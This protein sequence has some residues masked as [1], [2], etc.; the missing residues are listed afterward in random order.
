MLQPTPRT[1]AAVAATALVALLPALLDE[2]TWPVWT[3]AVGLVTLLVGMDA[4]IVAGV[5]VGRL[6]ASWPRRLYV[7]RPH[8]A[9]LAPSGV[10]DPGAELVLE[11]SAE[12]TSLP[13]SRDAPAGFTVTLHPT[14]RGVLR[15]RHAWLRHGGP[16]GLVSR[17]VR[18]PVEV[19][20]P[21]L[22]DLPRV[23]AEALR[24]FGG[25]VSQTGLKVEK[26]AGDGS[27]CDAL[28]EFVPG[29]DRRTIDWKASARHTKLLAREFRA[30]RNHPVVLAIDTGR[31]MAEP[32][33]GLP[34]L[35][36]AVHAALLLAWVSARHGDRTG[37]FT[38]AERPGVYTAPRAGRRAVSGLVD[39]A[40]RLEYGV[41]ETNHTLG[42]TTL[43]SR[44]SRRTLVIV[45]T[46]F[47]DTVSA[48]LMIDNLGRV[49]RRHLTVFVSLRDP[50]LD[51]MATAP[52]RDLSDVDRAVVT[53]TLIADR[54]RVLGRLERLGIT[55]IDAPPHQV[56]PALV[57]R[58]LD[59]ARRERIG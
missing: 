19:E 38:Y 55:C 49:A 25:R 41:D 18:L 27:E 11:H 45:L 10:D 21:V 37:M 4:V 6:G 51:A 47:V 56:G 53:E 57:N 22:P 14:R 42:L 1:L 36:H 43:M 29:V 48:E 35:D 7:G 5:T 40:G 17:V 52:P 34:R 23:E 13:A 24:F 39:L 50:G 33:G 54:A 8:R 32:V 12:A 15:I 2:R 16:L 9:L 44:L 31:L 26:F 59:I 30:E 28:R 20:L 3:A 58:Y 46:D